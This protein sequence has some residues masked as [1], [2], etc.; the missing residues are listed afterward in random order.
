MDS[1]SGRPTDSWWRS[2]AIAC[3]LRRKAGH[4]SG[5]NLADQSARRRAVVRFTELARAPRRVD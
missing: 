2:P 5:T 1:R 3:A 4:G